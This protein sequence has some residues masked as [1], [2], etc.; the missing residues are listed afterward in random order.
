MLNLKEDFMFYLDLLH[1]PKE[2]LILYLN[3]LNL[4]DKYPQH[5]NLI[6][7]LLKYEFKHQNNF[8]EII[9]LDGHFD[10]N[11]VKFIFSE[12]N[13]P[14]AVKKV[15]NSQLRSKQTIINLEK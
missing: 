3:F 2:D 13:L 10:E 9:Y 15:I 6:A 11:D 14:I 5:C 8:E 7:E 4:R 12:L 1:L